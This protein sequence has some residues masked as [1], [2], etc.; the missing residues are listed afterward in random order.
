MFRII[1]GGISWFSRLKFRFWLIRFEIWQKVITSVHRMWP[2]LSWL[3]CPSIHPRRG[4]S[5]V[6]G[7]WDR[8]LIVI[9]V[10]S[11]FPETE[12]YCHWQCWCWRCGHWSLWT[13]P[14]YFPSYLPPLLQSDWSSRPACQNWYRTRLSSPSTGLV[15]SR[16]KQS[17]TTAAGDMQGRSN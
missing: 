7:N 16:N 2:A 6:T 9:S 5:L 3:H 1:D 4:K 10:I 11:I 15:D 12:E 8:Q 13:V 14:W 17:K